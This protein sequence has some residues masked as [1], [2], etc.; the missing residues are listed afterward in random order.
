MSPSDTY[1]LQ[2]SAAGRTTAALQRRR[3][4]RLVLDDGS[5]V[6]VQLDRDFN[7]VDSETDIE[8]DEDE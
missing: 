2:S 8:D 4:P 1:C 3:Q 5:Q 6:D 7:V